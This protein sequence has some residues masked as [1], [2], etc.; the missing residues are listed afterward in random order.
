MKLL[1]ETR[2]QRVRENVRLRLGEV[3]F[4]PE[5]GLAEMTTDTW[6]L[7]QN[8]PDKGREYAIER[9]RA[10]R[11]SH[12]SSVSLLTKVDAVDTSDPLVRLER[13]VAELSGALG[14]VGAPRTDVAVELVERRAEAQRLITNVQARLRTQSHLL[15][16]IDEL[17]DQ[18]VA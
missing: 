2:N 7:L 4:L 9:S 8:D 5:V 14:A 18:K 6:E 3:R 13:L 1:C 16:V 12:A 15:G 11:L 17:L 10:M